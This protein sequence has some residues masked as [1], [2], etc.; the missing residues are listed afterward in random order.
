MTHNLPSAPHSKAIGSLTRGSL[1]T[2]SILNPRSTRMDSS[3]CSGVL[4]GGS[5]ATTVPCAKRPSPNRIAASGGRRR[6]MRAILHVRNEQ[7]CYCLRPD[8]DD[9]LEVLQSTSIRLAGLRLVRKGPVAIP[10]GFVTCPRRS[11]A[12]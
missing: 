7:D 5:E 9:G 8:V 3:D 11:G 12:I 6:G 4:A 2:S 10:S 1:A